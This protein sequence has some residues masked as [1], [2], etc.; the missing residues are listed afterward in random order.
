MNWKQDL[1]TLIESTMAFAKDANRSPALSA[2]VALMT[3]EPTPAATPNPVKPATST[4]P[5]AV[6]TSERDEIRQRVSSFKA[7]Q[8][9]MARERQDF[10]LQMR[11]RMIAPVGS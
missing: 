5:V 2:P 7:H 9:R 3:A 8:E 6:A 4:M 10:Y 1:E 11:A